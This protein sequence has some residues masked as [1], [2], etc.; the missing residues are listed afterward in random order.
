MISSLV[1]ACHGMR[2]A[3]AGTASSGDAGGQAGEGAGAGEAWGIEITWPLL[4]S[5]A[6]LLEAGAAATQASRFPREASNSDLYTKFSNSKY[7]LKIC[8]HTMQAK[9]YI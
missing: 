1:Q 9:Q 3:Q 7:R 2:M 4:L 8:K 6:P 5:L